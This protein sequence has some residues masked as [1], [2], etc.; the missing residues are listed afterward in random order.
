MPKRPITATAGIVVVLGLI[1]TLVIF[2]F[3]FAY[4][5]EEKVEKVKDQVIE[6][7]VKIEGI[8]G[9]LNRIETAQTAMDDEVNR[10]LDTLLERTP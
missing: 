2:A 10:K 1:A 7:E 4:S 9:D 5:A 3:K 8:R 6:H